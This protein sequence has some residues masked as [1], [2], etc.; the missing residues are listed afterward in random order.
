MT[1][2]TNLRARTQRRKR[3]ILHSLSA[4]QEGGDGG[5][6]GSP[7]AGGGGVELFQVKRKFDQSKE[8]KLL[9]KHSSPSSTPPPK[10]ATTAA[11]TN[12]DVPCLIGEASPENHLFLIEATDANTNVD[13]A[14][15]KKRKN[16]SVHFADTL[17][18]ELVEVHYTQTMYSEEDLD[19]T[20][21]I[22]LLLSPKK[23]KF[24]FLHISYNHFEKN[25]ITTVLQQLPTMATDKAM[26]QQN[27]TGLIR[28]E[29]CRELIN[30]VAIQ[31]YDLKKDELLV[32]VV[33]GVY[34]K[35]LMKMAKPLIENKKII[36]AV[37][38]FIMCG[39]DYCF[40]FVSS[41]SLTTRVFFAASPRS[42]RRKQAER[43]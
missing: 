40:L 36:R 32:A 21:T 4:T 6:G 35:R 42:K 19:W 25:P 10:G 41:F 43:L 18:K 27:Y 7:G 30:T 33:E 24:E 22:V 2:D 14:V 3:R 37:S 38:Q 11:A 15:V 26:Q 12:N 8:G 5:V 23:K 34:G 29:A 39:C 31:S 28:A 16:L 17:G 1:N 9:L 20:R 13:N